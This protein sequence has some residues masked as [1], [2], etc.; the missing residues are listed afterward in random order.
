MS[1]RLSRHGTMKPADGCSAYLVVNDHA[2]IR[3]LRHIS[4]RERGLLRGGERTI[5]NVDVR[6]DHRRSIRAGRSGTPAEIPAIS[7]AGTS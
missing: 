2:T 3:H 6:W 4:S 7:D 1:R 5:P